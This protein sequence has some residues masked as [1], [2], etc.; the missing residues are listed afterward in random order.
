MIP[1]PCNMGQCIGHKPSPEVVV[2]AATVG[3]EKEGKG[4]GKPDPYRAQ[5][6]VEV[7]FVG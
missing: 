7:A 2:E 3:A 1:D 5:L 4:P 6:P